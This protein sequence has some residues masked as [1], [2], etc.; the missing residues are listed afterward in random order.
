MKY[1]IAVSLALLLVAVF[2][3]QASAHVVVNS[4]DKS[5]SA[6]LHIIPDDDPIAGEVV[7][8]MFD[9]QAGFLSDASKVTL[10]IHDTSS[11]KEDT[12]ETRRDGSL[13]S[14]DY[15]FPTQGT[16]LIRYSV[17]TNGVTYVFEQDMRVSRGLQGSNQV[18]QKY[19]WAEGLLIVAGIL[20]LVLVIIGWNKRH[21]IFAYSKL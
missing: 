10:A 8:L 2:S 11:Q 19:T 14:A 9:T 7:N 1:I 17:T 3:Q 5:N 4:I 13:V 18:E 15:T 12:V 16:Y 20:F 6:I 21:D